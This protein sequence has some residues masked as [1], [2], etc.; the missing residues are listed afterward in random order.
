[1]KR[2]K[3]LT[4]FAVRAGL[5]AWTLLA[6]ACAT[7]PTN[8]VSRRDQFPLDPREELL[9]PFS[10][11]TLRGCAAL[12]AGDAPAA[13]TAFAAARLGGAPRLAAEI[14]W[15]EA[16]VLQG[17]AAETFRSCER[18]LG[19]GD[20]TLPLLVACGEAHFRAGDAVQG[21]VLY[22]RA[23]A[24]VPDRPGVGRRAEELRLAARE[25]WL[26]RAQA[27]ASAKEWARSRSAIAEAIAISPESSA[28]RAA[29]GD[30]EAQAGEKAAALRRYRE[31]MEMEPRNLS[32]LEKTATLAL[33]LGEHA[34][35]VSAFERLAGSDPHF[36]P[37]AAEARFAFRVAN[38]PPAE[39]EAARASKL[40][41]AAA[42]ELVWW[43]VPE[44]R[45]ARVGAGAIASDAVSRRDSRSITRAVALGLLE[46]D[47]ETHRVSP[48]AHLSLPAAAKMLVRLFP[49]L[50]PPSGEVPCLQKVVPGILSNAEAVR[51][52]QACDLISERDGPAVSGPAFLRALDRARAVVE[53]ET[54]R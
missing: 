37:R 45:E 29:A 34:L 21:L 31:A 43:M 44:V 26:A 33:E 53:G 51:L 36:A 23:L 24:R 35:A 8:P 2:S 13:E 14:G 3:A 39:R 38:W 12:G 49:I 6:A 52:A 41:R 19:A 7:A 11:G 48:D 5:L 22:R 15:I 27:A 17:R 50:N 40:T 28:L 16:V 30:I 32:V 9:G 1:L 54:A 20:P 46:V 10:E 25:Q 42:A 4:G 18:L 47:H